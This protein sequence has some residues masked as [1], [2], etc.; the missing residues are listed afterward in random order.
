MRPFADD[1]ERNL[2]NFDSKHFFSSSSSSVYG[3]FFFSFCVGLLAVFAFG[4]NGKIKQTPF[5]V[6]ILKL[7]LKVDVNI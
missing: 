1:L 6:G 5:R 4:K 3:S 2:N 7:S